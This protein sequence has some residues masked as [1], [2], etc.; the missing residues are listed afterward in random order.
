[1]SYK[2]YPTCSKKGITV[3]TLAKDGSSREPFV[4]LHS[5]P[6]TFVVGWLLADA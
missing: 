5:V 1:V 4:L 6:P 3:Q 2:L